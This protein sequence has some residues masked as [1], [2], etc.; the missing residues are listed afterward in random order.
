[1][2]RWEFLGKSTSE[3]DSAPKSASDNSVT[4]D[5]GLSAA[6]LTPEMRKAWP[7]NFGLIYSVT[8]SQDDLET[9]I[10]VRNEGQESFEFQVLL[11]TYFLIKVGRARR[12]IKIR[13]LTMT[14]TSP[15]PP[16]PAS[17]ADATLTKLTT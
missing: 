5:F 6:N 4:L 11:H 17:M 7:Y 9:S 13:L 8:L 10:V 16:S 3:S 2:C 1:M 12:G 15:R 14:R